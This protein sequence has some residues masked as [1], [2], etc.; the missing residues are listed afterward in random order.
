M[1][2][3]ENLLRRYGEGTLS[4]EE[5]AELNRLTHR[6]Q[7][8][9]AAFGKARVIR[10][11]RITTFSGVA[12][13]LLVAGTIFLV[14]P[15]VDEGASALSTVAEAQTPKIL[16]AEG[17]EME[18]T[19]SSESMAT[20]AHRVRHYDTA[21]VPAEPQMESASTPKEQLTNV[22]EIAEQLEPVVATDEPIVACNTQCS[23][24]SVINDIWRF[25]RT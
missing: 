11:R 8:V 21:I 1:S 7:V 12:A 22:E 18:A 6:D 9:Q 23:P 4:P 13:V 3:I 10:R 14:Q 15:S 19:Y 20:T 24:D 17:E 2:N 5:L 25:L 16:E